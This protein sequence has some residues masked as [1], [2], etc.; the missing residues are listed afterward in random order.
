MYVSVRQ[1]KTNSAEELIRRMNKNLVPLIRKAPGFIG[2]H[3]ISAGNGVWASISIFDTETNAEG[4]NRMTAD[5]AKKN[6]RLLLGPPDITAGEVAIG[7]SGR[8]KKQVMKAPARRAYRF[9]HQ[10]DRREAHV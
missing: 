5:W 8:A 2:Y 3:C 6:E 7:K 9:D 4:S 10:G 1:Y